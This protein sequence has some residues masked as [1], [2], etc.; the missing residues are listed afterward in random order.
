[1]VER[2]VTIK[3]QIGLHAR[4]ATLVVNKAKTYACTVELVKNGKAYNAKSIMGVLS[5]G[6]KMNDEIVVRAAGTDEDIAAVELV[7][8][9]E[10]GFGEK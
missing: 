6:A 5:M 2:N 10:S 1:M 7:E 3:N 8:L 9:I 4:P